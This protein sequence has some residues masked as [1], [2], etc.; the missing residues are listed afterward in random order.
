M[1]KRKLQ[2]FIQRL[3]YSIDEIACFAGIGII[4]IGILALM[5]WLISVETKCE[6]A[7][8]PYVVG[9]C[10]FDETVICAGPESETKNLKDLEDCDNSGGDSGDNSS[11]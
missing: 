1:F 5:I 9:V 11:N 4:V 3:W 2:R 10:G 7:C 8:Y 6:A